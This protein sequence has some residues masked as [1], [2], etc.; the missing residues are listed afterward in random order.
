[1]YAD[2]LSM[3]CTLEFNQADVT[4]CGRWHILLT[5]LNGTAVL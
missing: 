4:R 1:M 5:I 3:D 2:F